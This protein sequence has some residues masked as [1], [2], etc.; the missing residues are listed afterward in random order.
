[1]KT[2]ILF[3]LAVTAA[4]LVTVNSCTKTITQTKDVDSTVRDT[5]IIRDTALLPVG[6]AAI[7]FLSMFPDSI[8]TP[9]KFSTTSD[10]NNI[11][12]YAS[13][14]ISSTYLPVSPTTQLTYYLFIPNQSTYFGSIP[15]PALGVGSITTIAVFDNGVG[16]VQIA[17]GSDSVKLTPPPAGYCYLRFA[18]GVNDYPNP[19]AVYIDLDGTDTSVFLSNGFDRPYGWREISP[20]VLIPTGHHL[21]NLRDSP[22]GNI[23][24]QDNNVVFQDSGYYT[25]HI[26]GSQTAGSVIFAIDK[27]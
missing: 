3:I 14:T 4:F 1:M 27:E 22:L 21:V 24:Y 7:R 5:V 6:G 26:T 2:P 12:F 25:A 15:L 18:N 17:L 9:L 13:N 20:Y 8:G 11:A 23:L 19:P 10:G 16:N